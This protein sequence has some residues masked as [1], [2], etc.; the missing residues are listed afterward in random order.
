MLGG[1]AVVVVLGGLYMIGLRVGSLTTDG[2]I[3]AFDLDSEGSI[4]CW[5][6]ITVYFLCGLHTLLIRKLRIGLGAGIFERRAWLAISLL[7]FAMSLDEGASLHEGFKELMVLLVGTR[8][9]GDGSIYWV[10]PYFVLLAMAGM[11]LLVR[12]RRLPWAVSCLLGS[13]G[14]FAIAIA[15]QLDLIMRGRPLLETW[16]EESCEMLGQLCLLHGLALYARHIGLSLVHAEG[17]NEAGFAS[18]FHEAHPSYGRS[19]LGQSRARANDF[20]LGAKVVCRS[21]ED[22]RGIGQ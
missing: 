8:V 2:I 15:G 4:A 10:V 9:F 14:L 1:C 16:I 13:G 12:F 18:E 20:D 5:M 21:V 17:Q 6:S 7:W 3:A 22:A 11:Y 19:R